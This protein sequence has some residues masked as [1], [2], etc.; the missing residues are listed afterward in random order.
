[1]YQQ[2]VGSRMKR[3][4]GFRRKLARALRLIKVY[5]VLMTVLADYGRLHLFGWVFGKRRMR[6]RLPKRHRINARRVERVI[7]DVKGLFVKVGQMISIMTNFLPEEFREELKGVQDQIPPRPWEEVALRLQEEL[8]RSPET[9]FASINRTPLASASLAQVHEATL[10]DGRR[11]ALKIQ[12]LAIEETAE[13]DLKTMRR[14]L[15]IGGLV[16]GMRGLDSAYRQIREMILEELNFAMEAAYINEISANLADVPMVVCPEVVP[17]LC[18]DRIL[19][20]LLIEGVKITDLAA[21]EAMGVD[22]REL[23]ARVLD[24]YCRMLFRDG[25]Y[26]ADPHPGNLLVQP[27]GVVVFLD[28]GAVG[29]LSERMKHGVPRFLEA[30]LRRDNAQIQNALQS[31]GFIAHKSDDQIVDKIIAYFQR[32]FL[33]QVPLE[34]WSL[35]DFHFDLQT[36]MEFMADFRDLDI[37]FN[38]LMSTFQIPREWTLLQRTL[39]LL[40][41]LTTHLDPSMKPMTTIRPYLKEV[42]LDQ[43]RDW[44]AL[45]TGMIRDLILSAITIPDELKR[46]LARASSGELEVR[47]HGAQERTR[48]FYALG[49]QFLFGIMGLGSAA[50]A[51]AAWTRGD[52]LVAQ[53]AAG[54]GGLF[55]VCLAFAMFSARKWR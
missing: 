24:A 1:M 53:I 6:A 11:V 7:L 28:F 5:F 46:F 8:G 48:L 45:A 36:K 4:V 21:I 37:S 12:H 17:E 15:A 40:M 44:R 3:R 16:T 9:L 51:Y 34:S 23:A 13:A 35:K 14:I 31:L 38:D 20:T 39:L 25:L 43:S 18:T 32:R 22:R 33:E 30:V 27:G 52:V 26:H 41:G 42:V 50:L 54:A 10:H 29:R 2:Q 19:T 47:V 49:H 55:G